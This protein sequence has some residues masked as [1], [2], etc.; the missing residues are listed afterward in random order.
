MCPEQAVD[1]LL[2]G[3]DKGRLGEDRCHLRLLLVVRFLASGKAGASCSRL[4]LDLGNASAIDSG[5]E[6]G[7]RGLRGAGGAL[8]IEGVEVEGGFPK[9]GLQTVVV[10]REAVAIQDS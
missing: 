7:S 3:S 1:N 2:R 6:D 10:N 8:S 4:R 9:Q 5:N